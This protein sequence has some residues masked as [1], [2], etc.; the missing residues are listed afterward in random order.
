MLYLEILSTL[1]TFSSHCLL[2]LCILCMPVHAYAFLCIP[3][4]SCA[5]RQGLIVV[6]GF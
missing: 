4:R 3:M 2:R 5:L 1:Y 6:K